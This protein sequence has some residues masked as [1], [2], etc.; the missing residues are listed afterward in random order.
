MIGIFILVLLVPQKLPK[1][2]KR[3]GEDMGCLRDSMFE[4][5]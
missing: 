1:F 2:N 4:D 5:G 3:M